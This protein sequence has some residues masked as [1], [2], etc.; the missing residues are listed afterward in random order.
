MQSFFVPETARSSMI[1][2]TTQTETP[3]AST[4]KAVP[5]I[6]TETADK[7]TTETTTATTATPSAAPVVET[8]EPIKV[9][10]PV[11]ETDKIVE[12]VQGLNIA[13]QSKKDV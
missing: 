11:A 10:A 8:A 6:P 5:A 12:G 7:P 1:Y 13:E 4:S 2:L 3:V 9:D